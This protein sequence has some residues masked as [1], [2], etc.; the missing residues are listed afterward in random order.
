MAEQFPRPQKL[1]CMSKSLQ[2]RC[3]SPRPRGSCQQGGASEVLPRVARIS[4]PQGVV[5]SLQGGEHFRWWWHVFGRQDHS[6]PQLSEQLDLRSLFDVE[7]QGRHYLLPELL[8]QARSLAP[9][10]LRNEWSRSHSFRTT[11]STSDLTL[12]NLTSLSFLRR[13][14]GRN[15]ILNNSDTVGVIF[16]HKKTCL[17]Q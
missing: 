10:N 11:S 7:L 9:M 14:I 13:L 1:R 16:L 17:L 15:N 6:N 5:D 4:T 3:E 12:E 8:H 2:T